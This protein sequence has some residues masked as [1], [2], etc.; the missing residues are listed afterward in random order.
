M[1]STYGYDE[2]NYP[3]WLVLDIIKEYFKL[4]DWQSDDKYVEGIYRAWVCCYKPNL[5]KFLENTPH[6]EMV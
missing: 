1:S 3:K 4:I 5:E 2:R 6:L